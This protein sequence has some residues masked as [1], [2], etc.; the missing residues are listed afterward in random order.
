MRASSKMSACN[1]FEV[2]CLICKIILIL[3]V[4]I[5]DRTLR[6]EKFLTS[7]QIFE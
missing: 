3:L 7:F 6:L 2:V 1:F 5:F 4:N